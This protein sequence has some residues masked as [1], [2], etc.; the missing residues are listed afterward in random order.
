MKM[1]ITSWGVATLMVVAFAG[2]Y[3][4]T[5]LNASRYKKK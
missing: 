3:T 2:G 1:L 5:L 4:A